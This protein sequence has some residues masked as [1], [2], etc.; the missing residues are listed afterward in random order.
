MAIATPTESKVLIMNEPQFFTMVRANP[1]RGHLSQSAVDTIKIIFAEFAKRKL[2]DPRWLSYMLATVLAECGA[3]MKP[4]REGFYADDAD[5]RAYVKRKNYAYALVVNGQVYYGRGLLQLT[6][7]RNYKIMSGLLGVDL[8]ANPDLALKLDVAV[9]IM[10]EG[11]LK[12]ASGVG[13]FTGQSLEMYFNEAKSD[14]VG[15]R[16]IING[17]DRAEEIAGYY[18]AFLAAVRAAG[19]PTL[20]VAVDNDVAPPPATEPPSLWVKFKNAIGLS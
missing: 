10:F 7:F 3:H 18:R 5:A 19:V 1:M 9:Q 13:D 20:P 14:P 16:R 2:T 6:W 17:Q 8:V 15:A 11:M 4:V 12:A